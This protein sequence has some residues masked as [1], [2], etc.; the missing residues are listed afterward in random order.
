VVA[1]KHKERNKIVQEVAERSQT[2][3]SR[4]KTEGRVAEDKKIGK[5]GQEK[6]K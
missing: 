5:T 3:R 4:G 1:W 2:R 6:T